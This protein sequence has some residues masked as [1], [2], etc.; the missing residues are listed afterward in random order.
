[1]NHTPAKHSRLYGLLNTKRMMP[2]RH[3][4]FESYS[5]NRTRDSRNLNDTEVDELIRFL[6]NYSVGWSSEW[7]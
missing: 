1:M 6:E 3:D 2:Q 4:L 5:D 7:L